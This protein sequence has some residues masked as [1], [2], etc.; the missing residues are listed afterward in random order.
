[1]S[2]IK[3][4]LDFG[5]WRS[6]YDGHPTDRTTPYTTADLRAALAAE[7]AAALAKSSEVLNLDMWSD[8][9]APEWT[10]ADEIQRRKYGG[11]ESTVPE[12]LSP[13]PMAE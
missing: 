9:Y 8:E 5:D 1:M 7:E 4:R 3:I 12:L 10:T 11:K 2:K 13:A 6:S